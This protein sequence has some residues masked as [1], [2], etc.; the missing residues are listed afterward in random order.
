VGRDCENTRG[1]RTGDDHHRL[2]AAG[3]LVLN[4]DA[5]PLF[6]ELTSGLGLALL[7][8]RAYLAVRVTAA[9]AVVGLLRGWG[10]G[11]YPRLL[12]SLGWLYSTFQ[13]EAESSTKH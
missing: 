12:P 3:P 13:R 9:L 5:G 7:W 11:Q 10:L 6:D 4:A 1:H 2:L 8:R